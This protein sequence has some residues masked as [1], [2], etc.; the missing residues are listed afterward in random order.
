MATV[1]RQRAPSSRVDAS[2]GG[3]GTHFQPA[4][5]APPIRSRAHPD[6]KDKKPT[7]EKAQ[8]LIKKV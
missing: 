7:P 6:R 2:R 8:K 4:G 3:G 1:Q 5:K